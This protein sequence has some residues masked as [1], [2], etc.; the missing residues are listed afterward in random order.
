MKKY[1]KDFIDN[2]NLK[3]K[4]IL[5]VG[6]GSG[7][8]MSFMQAAG[9]DVIG[10]EHNHESVEN[11][12]KNGFIV[13]EGF[14]EGNNFRIRNA[15]FGAFYI[16]NF[17]EHI[18]DPGDFLNAISDNLEDEAIG[19]IEVPNT[20]KIIQDMMFSEFM[21]DHLCYYTKDTLTRLLEINGFDVI[22][23]SIVWH[24]YCLCVIV[25]KRSKSEM[26]SFS[27]RQE[28]IIK[29]VREFVEERVTKGEKVAIWGA[30]HQA[31]AMLSLSGIGDKIEF[32]IDSASFKQNRYT[33]G[34]HCLV[35]APSELDK[36]GIDSILVMAASYSDEVANIIKKQHDYIEVAIFRENGIEYLK[37]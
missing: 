18:P 35:V 1:F 8:F 10:L 13:E 27:I 5:E 31:L 36:K 25:K 34:S 11:A 30:G 3:D 7:E 29:E 23:S 14:P 37:E 15:P 24:D 19:L 9:G 2:Y 4:R 26:K 21:L 6:A 28:S 33:P 16:M 17:W 20:D 32:V 12:K 22:D